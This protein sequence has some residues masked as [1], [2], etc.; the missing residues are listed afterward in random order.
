[1]KL[2]ITQNLDGSITYGNWPMK[3]NGVSSKLF[4][5][6][7]EHYNQVVEGVK[8]F[9]IQQDGSL[10]VVN[11]TRKSDLDAVIA[12]KEAVMEVQRLEIEDLKVKLQDKTA[13]LDEIQ[14]ALL[15]IL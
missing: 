7:D 9:Q 14:E 15:K 1:M 5:V 12:E 6:T 2:H 4:D 8:D 10:S 11:S 3:E 13:T